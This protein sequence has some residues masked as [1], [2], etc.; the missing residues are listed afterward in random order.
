MNQFLQPLPIAFAPEVSRDEFCQRVQQIVLE[1][2][3]QQIKTVSLYLTD[4]CEF[5][6]LLLACLQTHTHILL[7]PDLL[8]ENQQWARDNS[9]LFIDDQLFSTFAKEQIVKSY[10]NLEQLIN[11]PSQSEIFL[12]T[13]GSSGQAK[14]IKRKAQQLWE[15]V[16]RLGKE[17]QFEQ[18]VQALRSV[19]LQHMY[20]LTFAVFLALA[21]GW[22]LGRK[23]LVYSEDLILQSQKSPLACVWINSPTLLN[24]ILI[25]NPQLEMAKPICIISSGGEL[26][27]ATGNNLRQTLGIKL[28]EIYGSTETGAI[29][30]RWHHRD[31]QALAP[32]GVDERGAL[33]TQ[34]PWLEAREQTNDAIEFTAQGFKLLGRLDR[35]VKLN[36]KRVSLVKMERDLL[37]S[38]LVKDCYI[39]LHPS[40]PRLVV[41]AELSVLGKQVFAEQDKRAVVKLLR[42]H[43]QLSQETSVLPRYWRFIPKLPRNS[44]A[45]IIKDEII[46]LIKE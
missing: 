30:G 28:L 16:A 4:T 8:P 10:S 21:Q 38:D 13:S 35:I 9:D 45:K 25:P 1:L 46:E 15:E 31:W 18:P 37:K 39:C 23:Q 33:W 24:N 32:I 3:E 22:V 44:Q 20:G 34:A 26:P 12:K 29:A 11:F 17:L 14:I 42:Q 2:Q 19:S 5:A 27:E 40:Q 6:C 43:L 36:D 41:L 7:P